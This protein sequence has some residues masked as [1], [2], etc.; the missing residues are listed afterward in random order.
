MVNVLVPKTATA[1]KIN[2]L[3]KINVNQKNA[4]AKKVAKLNNKIHKTKNCP[5]NS[6]G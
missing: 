3:A 1:K 4:N 5:F 2:V 6:K